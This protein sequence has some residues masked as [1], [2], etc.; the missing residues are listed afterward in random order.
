VAIAPGR[1][2][3]A[4]LM[5]DLGSENKYNIQDHLKNEVSEYAVKT[6]SQSK[7]IYELAIGNIACT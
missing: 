6:D 1:S 7:T 5:R 4:E 2:E 3:Q